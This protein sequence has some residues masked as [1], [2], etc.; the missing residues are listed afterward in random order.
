MSDAV[1]RRK[2]GHEPFIVHKFLMHDTPRLPMSP[3]RP[4]APYGRHI[5]SV[6][7]SERQQRLTN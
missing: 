2:M 6:Y 3:R 1:G 7:D 5:L 4:D